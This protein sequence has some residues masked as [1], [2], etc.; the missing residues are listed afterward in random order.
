MNCYLDRGLDN[1]FISLLEQDKNVKFCRVDSGVADV[2][3]DPVAFQGC[4]LKRFHKDTSLS[5]YIFGINI[6]LH[7]FSDSE[8]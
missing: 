8:K 1:Q 3:K 2:I 6:I 7:D 4:E 5:V